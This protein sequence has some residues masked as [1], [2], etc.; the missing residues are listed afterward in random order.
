MHLGESL[1]ILVEVPWINTANIPHL[2]TNSWINTA[3]IPQTY[4]IYFR[5]TSV[6]VVSVVDL[7]TVCL[8]T[9]FLT[10]FRFVECSISDFTV[11][12]SF[13]ED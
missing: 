10:L 12:T 2:T 7:Y 5:G 6:Y 9:D 8:Y 4:R 11:D 13:L 1:N 3:K